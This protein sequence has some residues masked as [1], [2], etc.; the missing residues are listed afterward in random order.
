MSRNIYIYRIRNSVQN[1]CNCRSRHQHTGSRGSYKRV[2]LVS[3]VLSQQRLKPKKQ[4]KNSYCRV[5]LSQSNWR[6]IEDGLQHRSTE[7]NSLYEQQWI[8][9]SLSPWNEM[10]HLSHRH[11]SLP[12]HDPLGRCLLHHLLPNVPRHNLL[13]LVDGPTQLLFSFNSL[14]TAGRYLRNRD[15]SG[16]GP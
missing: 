16:R 13:N 12:L 5:A 8:R 14:L 7:S 9:L 15:W 10:F 4:T 1:P 6:L 2:L 11:K 3:I